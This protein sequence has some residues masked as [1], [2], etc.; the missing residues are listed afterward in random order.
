M[1]PVDMART[2]VSERDMLPRKWAKGI[3]I[4]EDAVTSTTKATK[5]PTTCGK[6]KGKGT[7]PTVKSPEVSSDSEGVYATHLTTSKSEGEHQYPQ[8]DISEPVDDQLLLAQRDEM[9]CKRLNDPSR[10][11]VPLTTTPPPISD[12]AVVPIPTVQGPPP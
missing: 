1:R 7:T 5:L 11:W 10:I 4:N 8:A 9:R 12:Q 2:K 6:G 3:L